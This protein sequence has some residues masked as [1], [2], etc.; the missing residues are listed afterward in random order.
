MSNSGFRDNRFQ[1]GHCA[2]DIIGRSL[3]LIVRRCADVRVT[4]DSLND[5]V[6]HAEAIEIVA[7]PAAARVPAV[8]FGQGRVALVLVGCPLIALAFRL[9]AKSHMGSALVG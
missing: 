2:L 1:F 9:A 6:R 7:Q 8:P 3:D 4:E 5:H